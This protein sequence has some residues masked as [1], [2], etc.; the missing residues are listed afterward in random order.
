MKINPCETC[1]TLAIC[2]A[3]YHSIYEKNSTNQYTAYKARRFLQGICPILNSH[4]NSKKAVYIDTEEERL[5][6]AFHIF[7]QKVSK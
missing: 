7:M 3:R 6:Q 4:F 5:V 2:K 1:I